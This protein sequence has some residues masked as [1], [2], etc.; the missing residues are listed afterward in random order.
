MKRENWPVTQEHTCPA[1]GP[2]ICCYCRIPIGGEHE[3]DCAHRQRTVVIATTITYT[4][5]VPEFWTEHDIEFH[6]NESSYCNSN[7]ISELEAIDKHRGCLCYN[8]KTKYVREATIYDEN[9]DGI[10]INGEPNEEPADDLL[11]LKALT[12][13]PVPRMVQIEEEVTEGPYAGL[14]RKVLVEEKP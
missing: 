14:K 2:G 8:C 4:I 11:P 6:H 10:Y 12:C 5:E 3:P 9:G 13:D 1:G 7:M